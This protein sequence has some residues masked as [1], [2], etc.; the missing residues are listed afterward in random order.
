ME[1]VMWVV[2]LILVVPIMN[3]I[4]IPFEPFP[5]LPVPYQSFCPLPVP[6]AFYYACHRKTLA[7]NRCSLIIH[8][9]QN[10]SNSLSAFIQR[11]SFSLVLKAVKQFSDLIF[12]GTSFQRRCVRQK[13]EFLKTSIL[14]FIEHSNWS[15]SDDDILLVYRVNFGSG[16]CFFLR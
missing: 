1:C 2:S 15:S 9:Y 10:Q 6:F 11:Y 13:N 16:R 8:V 12:N 5:R 3:K 14:G 4:C 7:T